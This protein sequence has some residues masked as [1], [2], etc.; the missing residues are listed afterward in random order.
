MQYLAELS[1]EGPYTLIEFPD[2]PGCQTFVEQGEDVEAAA[3]EALEGWL[4]AYLVEGLT[5]PEPPRRKR[6]GEGQMLVRIDP[7]IAV[8]LK[9]RWARESAGLSQS[10]LAKRIGVSRQAVQQLEAPDANLRLSTLS[11]IADALGLELEIDL[12]GRATAA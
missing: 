2:A 12:V 1:Q 9:L 8:R 10:E 4:E 6:A 3:R 5:P 7:Q 11:K